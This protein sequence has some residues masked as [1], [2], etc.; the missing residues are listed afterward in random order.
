MSQSFYLK[1]I[2]PWLPQTS[3]LFSFKKSSF[4]MATRVCSLLIEFVN[5]ELITCS[6]DQIV[7]IKLIHDTAFIFLVNVIRTSVAS[8]GSPGFSQSVFT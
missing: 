7:D 4:A 3:P 2:I 8:M 1:Q 5:P 6:D